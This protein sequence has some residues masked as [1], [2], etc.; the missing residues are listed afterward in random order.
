MGV[1]SDGLE[2]PVVVATALPNSPDGVDFSIGG[3]ARVRRVKDLPISGKRGCVFT[4]H[5]ETLDHRWV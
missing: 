4:G 1:F 5:G 2:F 3:L